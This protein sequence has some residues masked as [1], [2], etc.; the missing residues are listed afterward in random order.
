MGESKQLP[1][2]IQ[3]EK[4]AL[5]SYFSLAYDIYLQNRDSEE[6]KDLLILLVE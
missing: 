4:E 1:S 2:L 5:L 6:G 3:Q